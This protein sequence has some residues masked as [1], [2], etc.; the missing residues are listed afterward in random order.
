MIRVTNRIRYKQKKQCNQDISR[1]RFRVKHVTSS[2]KRCRI[3]KDR[4]RNWLK[5]FQDRVMSVQQFPLM[6]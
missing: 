1:I 4:N 5:G 3:A 2:I 6:P